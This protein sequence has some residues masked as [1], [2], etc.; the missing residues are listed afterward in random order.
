MSCSPN[1]VRVIMI[2]IGPSCK[3]GGTLKYHVMCMYVSRDLAFCC[4]EA[5]HSYS[6]FVIGTICNSRYLNE[7][8]NKGGYME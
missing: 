2:L 5:M 4:D 7:L 8:D 6:L 3:D 1:Y